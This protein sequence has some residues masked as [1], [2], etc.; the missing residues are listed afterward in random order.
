[1]VIISGVLT[2]PGLKAQRAIKL[3]EAI[4]IALQNNPAVAVDKSAIQS[5][6]A[7]YTQAH[8]TF[9]P[10]ANVLSKYF[11]GNNLPGMYPLE[12]VEVPVLNNGNPTGDNI[13]MHPM[14]PFANNDRDVFTFDFNMVYPIYAGNKRVNAVESTKQL[15][16]AY[17]D[18]LKETEAGLTFKVKK[19]FYNNLLIDAVIKVY[20]E[21]LKQMNAHLDLAKKAYNEGVRS[22]FDIINFQS[23]VEE[24][25]SKIIE[26]KG[27][28]KVART[29]LKNLMNLPDTEDIVCEGDI[30][31]VNLEPGA[32]PVS[33]E[34]IKT[35]NHK[36]QSLEKMKGVLNRK[37]KIEAA[38]NMPT[39]FA[40][41]NYHV[42]HG[43]D[44]PPFDKT[45]RNGY[46]VGVGLKINL[47]DG[48][49]TK[50]KVQ[51]VKADM[52]KIDAY[53]EGLT[54][55]LRY[56]YQTALE[57][58]ESLKARETAKNMNLQVAEKA[59][60]IAEIGYKNGVTTN[61]ELN[62]AQVN[63][64]KIKTELLNIKKSLL[65]EYAKLE[66]LQ[67]GDSINNK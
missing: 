64:L 55:K 39:L 8:S 38:G 65:I 37:E 5:A 16:Q 35:G 21:A 57:N 12:G 6:E 24:F 45:W 15:K 50:G 10:K 66:Y 17:Y 49:M 20:E 30:E 19:A 36:L 63:V 67:G 32:L 58:I 47:F 42:Y 1:M 2:M 34:Q 9:L 46:A 4:S 28:R 41:G 60:H 11:Y 7:K 53:R 44:F 18:N 48:N 51:E 52:E 29:A 40:F 27:K 23:K 14:A 59:Y 61:I 54:L 13:V 62:D 33:L 3:E 31:D 56:E 22:E 43:M 26:L 25:K